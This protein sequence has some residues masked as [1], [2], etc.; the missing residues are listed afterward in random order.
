VLLTIELGLIATKTAD[1]LCWKN[2]LFTTTS[3]KLLPPAANY[4]HQLQIT[5]TSC[6]L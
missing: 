6:K 3:C 5:T 4:Y 2:I 1:I